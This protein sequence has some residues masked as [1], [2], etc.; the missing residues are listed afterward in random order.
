M[1]MIDTEP[2]PEK[3]VDSGLLEMGEGFREVRAR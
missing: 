1:C 3:R 2:F